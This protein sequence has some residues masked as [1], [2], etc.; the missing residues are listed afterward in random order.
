MPK[1]A[2]HLLAGDW[3]RSQLMIMVAAVLRMVWL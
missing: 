2:G 1:V 3:A